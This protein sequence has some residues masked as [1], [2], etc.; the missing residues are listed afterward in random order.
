MKG[1]RAA[2]LN[3]QLRQL[4][5]GVLRK[6]CGRIG[7]LPDSYLLPDEFDLSGMPRASGE[8]SDVRTGVFKGRDVAVKTLRISEADDKAKLRKVGKQVALSHP[9]LLI[10]RTALLQRSG[11][12]EEPVPS[13][14]TRSHRGFGPP[15][16]WEILYG[17]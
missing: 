5:L 13:K 15:R 1:L 12:M 3:T 9:G 2:S 4:A 17:L 7:H 6:L 14:R 10:Y 16:G 8:F 11:H